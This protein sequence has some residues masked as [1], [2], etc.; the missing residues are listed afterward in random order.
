MT[1]RVLRKLVMDLVIT[2]LVFQGEGV[3]IYINGRDIFAALEKWLI[4]FY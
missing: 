2:A 1:H 4:G 3:T